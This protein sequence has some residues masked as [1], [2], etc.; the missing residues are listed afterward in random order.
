LLPEKYPMSII[1]RKKGFL[2]ICIYAFIL[3]CL[4]YVA[5]SIVKSNTLSTLLFGLL[6]IP[7][8]FLNYLKKIFI[9]EGILN[10]ES[11]RIVAI[12]LNKWGEK[13]IEIPF[14]NLKSYTVFFPTS[15]LYSIQFY[16]IDGTEKE[17]TFINYRKDLNTK[18]SSEIVSLINDSINNYNQSASFRKIIFKMSFAA[19][20]KG[21]L[22]IWGLSILI[23]IA[24]A[25]HIITRQYQTI[26]VSL[27]CGFLL[28]M[29]FSSQRKIDLNYYKEKI[30]DGQS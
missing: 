25:L 27:I 14:A 21:K 26:P 17:F 8:F 7:I 19:S 29:Q 1:L 9:Y 12:I 2:V 15:E 23:I 30:A 3:L 5:N 24:I 16:M 22:A 4:L 28:L 18:S 11:S 20:G 10:I 13:A 6:V